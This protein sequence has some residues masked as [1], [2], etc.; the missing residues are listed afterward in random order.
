[1]YACNA[2]MQWA[3]A[4]GLGVEDQLWLYRETDLKK[5]K[6]IFK[7]SKKIIF[8][9]CGLHFYVSYLDLIRW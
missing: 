8:S 2:S 4:G 3:E 9:F 6:E 1:M 7:T 5:Q